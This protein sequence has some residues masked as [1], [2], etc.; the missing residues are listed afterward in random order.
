MNFHLIGG[1]KLVAEEQ[2]GNE[3]DVF[4]LYPDNSS[5]IAKQIKLRNEDTFSIYKEL[6]LLPRMARK[7]HLNSKFPFKHLWYG[8]W[9]E[10]L[11]DG[12]TVILFDS[13]FDVEIVEWIKKKKKN[14]R[15]IFWF[16]NPVNEDMY[17]KLK[18]RNC[19]LWSFDPEDCKNY[20]MKYNTQF[21]FN[22]VEKSKETIEYDIVFVGKDKGRFDYL[23]DLQDTFSEQGL[24]A[25]FHI[26]S[27]KKWNVPKGRVKDSM[28]YPVLIQHV[29]KSKAILDIVQ[30]GQSGLTL[31]SMESLFL[32]KKLITNNALINKYDFYRRENIFILGLD[33][34]D[35]LPDFLNTSYFKI[36]EET[37]EEY[38]FDQWIKRFYEYS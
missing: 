22:T 25:Y 13:I 9:K 16:W 30:A 31:R 19:E 10:K 34:P 23:K 3:K 27:D 6:S 37:I 28:S 7:F 17:K 12:S 4:I 38:D 20:G 5:F 8:D 36:H 2:T 32:E 35:E 11:T 26:V 29:A 1:V 14:S 18:N 24:H 21:Y 33:N 15:L